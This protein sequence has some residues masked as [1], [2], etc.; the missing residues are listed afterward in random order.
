MCTQ[1]SGGNAVFT[2][3]VCGKQ[4]WDEQFLRQESEQGTQEVKSK[5]KLKK[6]WPPTPP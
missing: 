2:G 1:C 5:G 6:D 4:T 3:S